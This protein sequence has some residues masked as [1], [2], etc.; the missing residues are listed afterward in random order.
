MPKP[1]A[2]ARLAKASVQMANRAAA[3]AVAVVVGVT[4]LRVAKMALRLG[5]LMAAP[6]PRAHRRRVWRP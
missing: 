4:A 5:W 6:L 2:M 1:L 3:A